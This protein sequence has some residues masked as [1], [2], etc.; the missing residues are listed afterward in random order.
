MKEISLS[1][2]GTKYKGK[3]VTIVDDEDYEWLNQYNWIVKQYKRSNVIY[4]QS[5]INGKNTYMHR[6]ILEQPINLHVD[7]I[8]HN[9]LDNRRSNLRLC[10][11][12]Q[13]SYNIPKTSLSTSS[14][15]KGVSYSKTSK[16]WQ[17]KYKTQGK[18]FYLGCFDEE[19]EAAYAYNDAVKQSF[20]EFAYL[21]DIGDIKYEIK[22]KKI[23]TSKYIG[24]A[25][26]RN[27]YACYI[28]LKDK[29]MHIGTFITELEAAEAYNKK[30]KELGL[31][32]KLNSI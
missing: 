31:N 16:K 14:I 19:I 23:P 6:L 21:N 17:A 29:Q 26:R 8:N 20:K 5:C 28:K 3:F 10:T 15:Y 24:V 32:K 30:V 18:T 25:R 9:G 12:I 1:K 13:N 22:P 27:K 11:R 4:C 2:N 7:H